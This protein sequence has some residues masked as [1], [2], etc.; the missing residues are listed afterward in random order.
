M[1]LLYITETYGGLTETFISDLTSALNVEV[2]SLCVVADTHQ[3]SQ[4]CDGLQLRSISFRKRRIRKL[5]RIL[6]NDRFRVS[7]AIN[8]FA[9]SLSSADFDAL[10]RE[11]KPDAA[12]IDFGQNIMPAAKILSKSNIP[13]LLHLHA[14]DITSL[15]ADDYYRSSLHSAFASAKAMVGPSEHIR[16]LMVLEGADPKKCHKVQLGVSS[17]VEPISW[18]ERFRQGI[19]LCFVGRFVSKKNP[20]ALVEMMRIVVSKIPSCKLVAIGSGP[21]VEPFIARVQLHGLSDNVAHFEGM[22]RNEAMQ[23]LNR[24]SVYVQH[25][26]T[27]RTGDQEG[28][29]VIIGEASSLGLP[30]V[31]TTHSGIVEQVV[32]GVN[33]YLVPENDFEKMA[34]KV[35]ALLNDREL[36]QRFGAESKRLSSLYDHTARARRLIALLKA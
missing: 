33:G 7:N 14:M 4:S 3:K 31:S 27:D 8:G 21:L 34:E 35:M 11:Y 9:N 32:D 22:P 29:P 30:I 28:W 17:I 19:S 36:I 23:I 20:I 6:Q 15:L 16:R 1:R 26:V 10:I 2:Q 18:E 12:I 25:S 13:F 5:A 24:A